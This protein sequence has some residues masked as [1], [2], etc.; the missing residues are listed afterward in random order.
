MERRR[1]ILECLR[2]TVSLRGARVFLVCSCPTRGGEA[3]PA[4][5]QPRR[6]ANGGAGLVTGCPPR[7]RRVVP[8]HWYPPRRRHE[9]ALL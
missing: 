3:H 8:V 9:N 7:R 4:D 6:D 5:E 1:S 2:L